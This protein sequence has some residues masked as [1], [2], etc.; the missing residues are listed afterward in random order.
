MTTGS[1]CTSTNSGMT[2]SP[3]SE[4]PNDGCT[5]NCPAD[6]AKYTALCRRCALSCALHIVVGVIQ[7]GMRMNGLLA[8]GPSDE[9]ALVYESCTTCERLPT[10]RTL[11]VNP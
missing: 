6:G 4:P 1:E 11:D 9:L 3:K 2:R 8:V 10:H 7:D 5:C